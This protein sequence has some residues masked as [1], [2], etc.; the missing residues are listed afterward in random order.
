MREGVRRRLLPALLWISSAALL[1]AL[2]VGLAMPRA[3]VPGP[4]QLEGPI[5]FL[6]INEGTT[7]RTKSTS[8]NVVS[9]LAAFADGSLVVLPGSPW[10]TGGRGPAGPVFVAA[11]R[12]GI[13]GLAASRRLFVVDQ[14]SDDV[15]VLAIGGDGG[16]SPV[17]GSPFRSDANTADGLALG[18]GGALLYVA[19]ADALSVLVSLFTLGPAGGL[20]RVGGSPFTGP[21]AGAN[22]LQLVPGGRTLAASLPNQNAVASF[23]IGPDGR[24]VA[25]AGSPFRNGPLGSAPTGMASD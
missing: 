9:G 20:K 17:P 23:A 11:P 3:R 24:P 25:A 12:L 19:Q 16:L 4:A 14:G 21:G 22:I 6:Y 13:C 15:A 7:D 18:R 1:L 5:G 10:F 2:A 8:D